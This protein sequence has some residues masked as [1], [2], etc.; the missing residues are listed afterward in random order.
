MSKRTL[1]FDLYAPMLVKSGKDAAIVTFAH[2]A[3]DNFLSSTKTDKSKTLWAPWFPPTNLEPTHILRTILKNNI[4]PGIIQSK[5]D[6]ICGD[7]IGLF[8]R[9]T[10]NG[11]TRLVAVN[12][13]DIED[14]LNSNKIN[15]LMR[16]LAKDYC[17]FGNYFLQL[18]TSE[19]KSKILLAEHT[20]ASLARAKKRAKPSEDIPGYFLSGHWDNKPQYNEANPESGNVEYLPAYDD[21]QIKS[22]F[23]GKNYTPGQSYYALPD[24]YGCLNWIYLANEIP[25]WHLNGIKNGYNIRY[26]IEIPMSYFDRYSGDALK[27]QKRD[28][29]REEMTKWL[30]GAEGS[31][32]TFMSFMKTAGS[33][34]DKFQIKP[35]SADLKDTAYSILF[36]QSNIAMTS[37]HGLSM[38]L[39]GIE[40][41]GKLSS[42]SEMRIAYQI[43]TE[44][45]TPGP[46]AILLEWLTDIVWKRNNW[47][48]DIFPAFINRQITTLDKNPTGTQTGA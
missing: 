22:I 42:G 36:D 18:I 38:N 23:H 1:D 12:N 41:A 48:K 47:P 17:F 35:I 8:R 7:G 3:N 28:E 45:K 13:T 26:H 37:G 46:R 6:F 24:W 9:I 32:K 33:E 11:K 16:K 40:T 30:S 20:D 21:S 25:V 2:G 19:D 4:N 10:E 44:L 14:W 43:Y 5:V 39:A 27:A 34:T 31:G 29:L 15:Q